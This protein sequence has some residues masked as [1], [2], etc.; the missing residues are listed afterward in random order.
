MRSIHFTKSCEIFYLLSGPD[1]QSGL[2]L[3]TGLQKSGSYDL[4]INLDQH[5]VENKALLEHI[6][7][8]MFIYVLSMDIFVDF[9]NWRW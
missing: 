1:V 6:Y 8:Q 2:L 7:L 3:D 4:C 5:V 9:K